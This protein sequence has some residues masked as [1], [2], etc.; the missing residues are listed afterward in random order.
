[1]DHHLDSLHLY[2][3]EVALVHLVALILRLTLIFSI[4][5][6]LLIVFVFILGVDIL[7]IELTNKFQPT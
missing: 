3:L 6:M 5:F 7:T 4:Y 2:P 1:M